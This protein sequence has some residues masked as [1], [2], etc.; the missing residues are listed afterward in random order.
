[1]KYAAIILSMAVAVAITACNG[2]KTA[3][4]ESEEHHSE[5][6]ELTAEQIKTVGIE[7]GTVEMKN[8]GSVVRANGQLMLLPQNKADVNS[9]SSG[10]IREIL[11]TEGT[12]VSKGQ[13]VA[14]LENLDIV[15]MQEIYLTAKQDLVFSEQE[16]ERQKQ[17]N[18]QNAGTGKVF[19]QAQAKYEADRARLKSMEAQLRQL[20]ISVSSVLQGNIVSQIPITAPISGVAGEIFVKT[21]SY[22]DMQTTLMEIAELAT[23]MRIAGF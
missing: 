2:G 11:V 18:A 16:Y 19:Q 12:P 15:K 21:G 3:Q 10:I 1:M 22:A 23:S 14:T 9:L 8:L 20:N 7:L 5:E 13:T 17:L 6:I 4:T